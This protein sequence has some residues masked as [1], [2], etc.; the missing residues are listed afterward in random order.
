MRRTMTIRWVVGVFLTLMFGIVP[1]A[2]GQV[3]V[4][5]I[6]PNDFSDE[7][8]HNSEPYIAVNP[9]NRNII[10]VSVF[11]PTPA[12][13]PNGPLLVSF[14]GGTTWA[15]RNIIPSSPGAFFNTGDITIRFNTT[16]TRLYA[17]ILRAGG[18]G[19]QIIQT[20]DMNLNTPMT[21]LN[22]PRP[23]DQPYIFARTA[24]G[25]DRV[26]VANNDAGNNPRSATVDQTLDA[27]ATTPAFTQIRIDAG[28]V[29]GRDNY[30]VRTI[31]A[32]D[33]RTYAAFYRRRGAIAGGYNAT[34][35]SSA[36]TPGAR[37]F[38]HSRIWSIRSRCSPG[39]VWSPRRR[40]RTPPAATR[41]S[42]TIGGAAISTS[43]SIRRC[44]RGST[45]PIPIA[46][47]PAR[48][49]SISADPPPPVRRGMRT[50]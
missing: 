6:I 27:A 3:K 45:S 12:A 49:R 26:W 33:G 37:R 32:A 9:T 30:Q 24:A 48:G 31:G 43:P 39:S 29:V 13:S 22:T 23:T 35:W 2:H 21:V 4:V 36:T 20:N 44:R 50:C 47:P 15:W 34:S 7:T 46:W 38:P 40:S 19:L 5:D 11:M 14:D 10:A 28:A 25:L 18:A 1:R 17:G 16:G 42:A 41:R 8:R